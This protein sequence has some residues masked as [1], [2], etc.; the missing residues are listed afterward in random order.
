M[1]SSD[2]STAFRPPSASLLRR[3]TSRSLVPA[4]SSAARSAGDLPANTFITSGFVAPACSVSIE[5]ESA[6][7]SVSRSS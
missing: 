5:S 6:S 7:L 2:C 3:A 1:A 4:T